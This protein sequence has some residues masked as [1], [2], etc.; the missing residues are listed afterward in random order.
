MQPINIIVGKSLFIRSLE[1]CSCTTP[2]VTDAVPGPT[3]KNSVGVHVG[4]RA[5]T[6]VLG[7]LMWTALTAVYS[8]DKEAI[9]KKVQSVTKQN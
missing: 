9:W 3:E 1:L 2:A 8:E 4:E 7:C 6:G 5:D